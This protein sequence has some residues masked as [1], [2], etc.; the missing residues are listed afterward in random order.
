[1]PSPAGPVKRRA[2]ASKRSGSSAKRARVAVAVVPDPVTVDD[3]VAAVPEA[4]DAALAAPG[5]Q[6]E[7]TSSSPAKAGRPKGSGT[8]SVPRSFNG[9]LDAALSRGNVLRKQITGDFAIQLASGEARDDQR[10]ETDAEIRMEIEEANRETLVDAGVDFD[11]E[12]PPAGPKITLL[13][14]PAFLIAKKLNLLA[15]KALGRPGVAF[16]LDSARVFTGLTQKSETSVVE[17][18]SYDGRTSA[19]LRS[20][21]FTASPKVPQNLYIDMT[22]T[23]V[24]SGK[25]VRV[26]G[27]VSSS[28]NPTGSLL[29]VSSA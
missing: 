18:L 26:R 20:E 23:V 24:T 29:H 2:P 19:V 11:A 12:K 9:I 16:Y 28:L 7:P 3:P 8:K 1:M 14:G 21:D 22:V 13:H 6:E 15:G 17:L 10:G 4:D 25:S 5:A 27:H